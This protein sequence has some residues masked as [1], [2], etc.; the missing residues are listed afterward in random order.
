[1][2]INFKYILNDAN[3]L[4]IASLISG[5]SSTI[6]SGAYLFHNLFFVQDKFMSNFSLIDKKVYNNRIFLSLDYFH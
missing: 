1:M 5:S 2:N 4:S 6:K 3:S